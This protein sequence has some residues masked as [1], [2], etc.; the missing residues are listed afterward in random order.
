MFVYLAACGDSCEDLNLRA[1]IW[2][3]IHELGLLN[4]TWVTGHW[5]QTD[6]HAG[7]PFAMPIPKSLKPGKYLLRHEVIAIHNEPRQIYP[8]C[9]QIEVTG[10]RTAVPS[11]D[12]ELV[13]FPGAYSISGMYR[14]YSVSFVLTI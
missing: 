9:V 7:A 1:P 12:W 5:G 6:L 8:E 13:S 4:G 10:S 14:Q 2:F 3:K 11:S